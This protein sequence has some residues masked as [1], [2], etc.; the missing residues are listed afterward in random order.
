V[1]TPDGQLFLAP[2]ATSKYPH[3]RIP[4]LL[5]DSL[6]EI[7]TWLDRNDLARAMMV[8][9]AFHDAFN[10][11]QMWR[12]RI[13]AIDPNWLS[14]HD[15]ESTLRM[16][17]K[18]PYQ[19]TFCVDNIRLWFP[20][21]SVNQVEIAQ[22]DTIMLVGARDKQWLRSVCHGLGKP[23]VDVVFTTNEDDWKDDALAGRIVGFAKN[24]QPWPKAIDDLNKDRTVVMDFTQTAFGNSVF[25]E[26][27]D[28]GCR[29]IAG[30]SDRPIQNT[31]PHDSGLFDALV[32][33]PDSRGCLDL[34]GRWMVRRWLSRHDL[35]SE[36]DSHFACNADDNADSL[37]RCYAGLVESNK[38]LGV[39]MYA[40]M[41]HAKFPHT[42][43]MVPRFP[44]LQVL[45]DRI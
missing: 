30:F 13:A 11:D 19:H 14:N 17:R 39:H 40:T 45:F 29:C 9:R 43:C 36:I 7:G 27:K 21:M 31:E 16:L 32:V 6:V 10:S 15:V 28:V 20:N 22:S 18:I 42:I 44:A 23:N 4:M 26:I 12:S 1:S 41:I 24:R 8:C 38:G 3:R 33:L 2:L 34:V 25:R 5:F 35:R 37:V